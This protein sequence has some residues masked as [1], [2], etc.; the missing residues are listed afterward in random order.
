[1]DKSLQPLPPTPP[2]PPTML[3]TCARVRYFSRV[4][5]LYWRRRGWKATHFETDNSAF[6][7]NSVLKT[8]KIDA[9][10]Q[11]SQGILST[12]AE[13]QS[14]VKKASSVIHAIVIRCATASFY[15]GFFAREELDRQRR[16]LRQTPFLK[17]V[18]HESRTVRFSKLS[19]YLRLC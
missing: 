3:D 6:F 11:V 5:T 1:M 12:I 7:L 16:F 4:S 15:N 19:L 13:G 8:Q 14:R 17:G 18:F 9:I 2:P 10:T